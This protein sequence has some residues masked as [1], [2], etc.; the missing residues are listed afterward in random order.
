MTNNMK[1]LLAYGLIGAS[2][3]L[4]LSKNSLAEEQNIEQKSL[5]R[6]IM[7]NFDYPFD[8]YDSNTNFWNSLYQV[9]SNCNDKF[10]KFNG[11]G[12]WKGRLGDVIMGLYFSEMIAYYQHENAHLFIPRKYGFKKG[13]NTEIDLE[14]G[15]WPMIDEKL[16]NDILND[17]NEEESIKIHLDGLN[18]AEYAS[19]NQWEKSFKNKNT[20]YDN[21]FLLTNK[22]QDLTY[23]LFSGLE[24][25]VTSRD[26]V[27]SYITKLNEKGIELDKKGYYN[28]VLFSELL[29]S[30]FY[31]S[32][33]SI[34]SYLSGGQD[35]RE[36]K[37]SSFNIG[38]MK[39]TWPIINLYMTSKGSYFDV[40]SKVNPHS[41]LP[42]DINF[43]FD[44][45]PM[46]GEVKNIRIGAE[47]GGIKK[48]NFSMRFYNY[49]NFENANIKGLSVGVKGK[50]HNSDKKGIFFD[51]AYNKEDIMENT[52]FGKDNGLN[53]EL[54]YTMK[55]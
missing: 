40:N 52:I 55:F 6:E 30:C 2:G 29:S 25:D 22:M 27:N 41:D 11:E 34:F 18:Q 53:L 42:I 38:D 50:V 9:T 1:N 31:E 5:E 28:Q 7:V 36:H 47:Y 15:L 39:M 3:L 51:L 10:R 20:F 26:D 24:E 49:L 54:G 23:I 12:D 46:G 43:G 14:R 16:P 35:N 45:D 44:A 19:Y 8:N 48:D 32:Y 33:A 17:M 37:F 4:G 13:F 21:I